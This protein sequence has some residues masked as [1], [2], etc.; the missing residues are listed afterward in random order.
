MTISDVGA[1]PLSDIREALAA[2]PHSR[3]MAGLLVSLCPKI[4]GGKELAQACMSPE[5]ASAAASTDNTEI[6]FEILAKKLLPDKKVVEWAG[7]AFELM[8]GMDAFRVTLL[9]LG[10]PLLG[11]GIHEIL[12]KCKRGAGDK[13]AL[14]SV[15]NSAW[16]NPAVH[17]A[18]KKP[19]GYAAV[20]PLFKLNAAT[21]GNLQNPEV[22]GIL[23]ATLADESKD[24]AIIL[25]GLTKRNDVPV[26]LVQAMHYSAHKTLETAR[27]LVEMPAH[28]QLVRKSGFGAALECDD[29]VHVD[30]DPE[31]SFVV[32]PACV[33]GQCRGFFNKDEPGDKI[34]NAVLLAAQCPEECYDYAKAEGDAFLETYEFLQYS[35]FA[36]KHLLSMGGRGEVW[37]VMRKIFEEK[38]KWDAGIKTLALDCIPFEHISPRNIAGLFNF[39]GNDAAKTEH[40]ALDI[41][42]AIRS[43][44]YA[45]ARWRAGGTPVAV[46][47]SPHTSGRQLEEIARNHEGLAVLAACHPNGR[48]IPI[49][50]I[51]EGW[52]GFVEQ[53]RLPLPQV[54]QGRGL[55]GEGAGGRE[56]EI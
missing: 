54:L 52:R 43:R 53:N 49:S 30:Q 6:V 42:G 14:N 2:T 1:L 4:R 55:G 38:R 40:I 19:P 39:R 35:P 9:A 18:D 45:D 12:D 20:S 10:S 17:G 50:S 24:S 21:F 22:A 28:Q 15:V 33:P 56:I 44:E 5:F 46:L 23:H 3:R 7:K 48:E 8:P 36:K 29:S 26:A 11:D 37:P 27:M 41:V 47:F 13:G 25:R 32:S 16:G 34:N 31:S 51:P